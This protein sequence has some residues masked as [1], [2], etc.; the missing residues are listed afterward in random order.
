MPHIKMSPQHPLNSTALQQ[1]CKTSSKS[2]HPPKHCI[3]TDEPKKQ[4]YWLTKQNIQQTETR[5]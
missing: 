4:C 2:Y 3:Y 1:Q 5:F